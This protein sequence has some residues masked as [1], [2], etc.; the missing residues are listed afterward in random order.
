[1]SS[2]IK[3]AQN[4]CYLQQQHTSAI[5]QVGFEEGSVYAYITLTLRGRETVFDRAKEIFFYLLETRVKK[6]LIQLY[7]CDSFV[8]YSKQH[9]VSC[10]K[11]IFRF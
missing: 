10:P 1:M 7:Y 4:D 11:F 9:Y 2:I 5:P 6:A 8:I 3:S